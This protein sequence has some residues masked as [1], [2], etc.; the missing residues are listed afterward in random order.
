MWWT[1][2]VYLYGYIYSLNLT[3]Q[4]VSSFTNTSMSPYS[5]ILLIKIWIWI[6]Q[7]PMIS[8]PSI[9]FDRVWSTLTAPFSKFNRL[10]VTIIYQSEPFITLFKSNGYISNLR[11][12]RNR[13]MLCIYM[14]MYI[15]LI[16]PSNWS[17]ILL[18][19]IC[20]H[21]L[22]SYWSRFEYEFH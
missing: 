17:Q 20:H 22:Q 7:S 15:L 21:T 16:W 14:V 6:S 19:P 1:C 5:S 3:I 11:M 12:A 10:I 18:T 2:V 13:H 9:K 8:G 4:L